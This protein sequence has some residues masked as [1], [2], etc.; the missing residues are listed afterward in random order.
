[1]SEPLLTTMSLSE[2]ILNEYYAG[3]SALTKEDID[4]RIKVWY[5]L[6]YGRSPPMWLTQGKDEL[7]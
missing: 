3:S 6:K 7:E 4:R 1:M 5:S 2:F